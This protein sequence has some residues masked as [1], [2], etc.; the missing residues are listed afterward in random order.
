[1]EVQPSNSRSAEP[2]G[3]RHSGVDGV[4]DAEKGHEDGEELV[5]ETKVVVLDAGD[6]RDEIVPRCEGED[7]RELG[8]RHVAAAEGRRVCAEGSAWVGGVQMMLA[9]TDVVVC[10]GLF[11]DVDDSAPL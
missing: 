3:L 2:L 10:G 9:L 8:D 6:A 1:M 4:N 5:G 7:E 11:S